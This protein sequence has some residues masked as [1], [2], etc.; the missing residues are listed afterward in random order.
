MY[1]YRSKGVFLISGF[2]VKSL[3]N[4]NYHYSKTINDI[5]MKLGPLNLPREK[6]HQKK[7]R[8]TSCRKIMTSLSFF[9]FMANPE[10]FGIGILKHF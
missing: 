6:P 9:Q 7:L 8:I 4:K 3:L 5:D 1:S 2:L 10:Q